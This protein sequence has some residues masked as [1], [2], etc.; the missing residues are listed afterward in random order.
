MIDSNQY[1]RISRALPILERAD[2]QLAREFQ[3]ATSIARI[4]AGRDI[5]VEGDRV[6]GIA[7]L[8]SV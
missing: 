1:N 2:S 4:P 7:L 6:D 3:Q 5:F 8:L